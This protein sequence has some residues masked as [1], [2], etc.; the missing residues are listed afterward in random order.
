MESRPKKLTKGDIVKSMLLWQFFSHANYNYERLQATAFAQCMGPVIKKLY[1]TKEEISAALK[2]HLVFFNTEP[3]FGAVIHGITIA[4]EEERA[5]GA[6]IT[7]EAINSVKTGLMGPLAGIGDTIVQG[8]LIPILLALGISFGVQ[9]N[10]FGPIMFALVLTCC[11]V[12][13]TY[14][15]WMQGYK[16]GRVAVEKLLEGG[17]VKDIIAAAGVLGCTVIGALAGKFVTLTTPL[18]VT[19]GK[20]VVKIQADLL[21]KLMPGLLPLGLTLLVFWLL[22]KGKSPITIMVY[23]MIFGAV[24]SFIKIF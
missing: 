13:I 19:I 7:D 23:L 2:R 21:D 20:T 3:D 14:S 4:M 11:L 18:T 9:G 10:V 17:I 6:P 22:K 16:L 5:N 15:M 8:A 1:Q 12:G 24:G